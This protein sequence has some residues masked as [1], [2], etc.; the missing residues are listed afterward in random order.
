MKP[1]K[2]LIT[3]F[4]LSAFY[5]QAVSKPVDRPRGPHYHHHSEKVAIAPAR[6]RIVTP[7][8]VVVV[9]LRPVVVRPVVTRVRVGSAYVEPR[10]SSREAIRNV[11]RMMESQ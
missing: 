6:V 1:S 4:I 7:R 10:I 8:P 3:G 11:K 9:A 5:H 2:L